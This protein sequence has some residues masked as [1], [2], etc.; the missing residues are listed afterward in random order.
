MDIY[1]KKNK[2]QAFPGKEQVQFMISDRIL[3]LLAKQM[4]NLASEKEILELRELL[5]Q[6]P[7]NHF[8]IEILQS[9]KS[10]RIYSEP[11]LSEDELVQESWLMLSNELDDLPAAGNMP[12]NENA[13]NHKR[14]ATW[15]WMRN[16]A[17]WT[18]TILFIAASYYVWKKPAKKEPQR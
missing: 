5:Q 2:E 10:E 1:F 17:I 16:A 7:E 6:S 18:G 9:I 12:V 8:F 11:V 14:S 4:G 15:L 13:E 3:Q